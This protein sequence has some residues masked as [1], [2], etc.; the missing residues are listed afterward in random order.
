MVIQKPS[1]HFTIE[2]TEG[3]ETIEKIL[4]ACNRGAHAT[5]KNLRRLRALGGS[6]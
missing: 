5:T 4:L 2:A 6:V 3:I 1:L